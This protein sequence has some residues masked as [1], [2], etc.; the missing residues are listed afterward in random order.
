MG[1]INE[2][3]FHLLETAG[4]NQKELALYLGVDES[5]ISTWKRRGTDPPS[6]VIL[7][8]AEYFRVPVRYLVE[9]DLKLSDIIDLRY[10]GA[11]GNRPPTLSKQEIAFALRY[12]ALTPRHKA[13]VD[14]IIDLASED[15]EEEKK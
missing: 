3:M 13:M 12:R 7:K 4:N 15:E 2:R 1:A 8:V 10:A 6:A 9:G 11:E 14:A 5:T